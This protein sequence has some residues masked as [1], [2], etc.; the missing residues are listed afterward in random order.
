M[1]LVLQMAIKW[2]WW[3]VTRCFIWSVGIMQL[4]SKWECTQILVTKQTLNA[5]C[6]QNI[7]QCQPVK[8]SQHRNFLSEEMGD[9]HSAIASFFH[10]MSFHNSEDPVP[11]SDMSQIYVLS[12]AQDVVVSRVVNVAEI[13]CEPKHM[14][15][16]ANRHSRETEGS[17]CGG[18]TIWGSTSYSSKCSNQ[19]CIPPG[20]SII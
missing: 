16:R 20:R 8:C 15:H 14:V 13:V 7:C 1:P 11:P 2:L 5:C 17:F 6:L 10:P 18:S 12:S 4:P 3:S 9:L 19:W